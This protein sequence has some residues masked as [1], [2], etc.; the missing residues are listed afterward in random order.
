MLSVYDAS[1]SVEAYMIL[2]LLES[3]GIKGRV[4][5]EFLTGGVGELQAIGIVQVAVADQDYD[6]AKRIV[7]QWEAEQP[8]EEAE[9]ELTPKPSY[10]L[11]AFCFGTVFGACLMLLIL[12]NPLG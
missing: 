10:T 7:T 12:S 1:N 6:A 8:S 9:E 3:E 4:D 5:G 11:F 2:N